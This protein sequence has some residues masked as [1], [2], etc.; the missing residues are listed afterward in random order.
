MPGLDTSTTPAITSEC[1]V[2]A[3]C[4]IAYH[5]F[6][7]CVNIVCLEMILITFQ[8]AM[9]LVLQ[10]IAKAIS[11]FT[12]NYTIIAIIFFSVQLSSY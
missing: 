2:V 9:Y 5:N 11:D 1:S 10:Y 8:N 7:Y 4:S 3:V 6:V 12:G